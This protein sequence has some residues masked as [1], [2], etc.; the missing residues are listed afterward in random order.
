MSISFR[1]WNIALSFSFVAGVFGLI[2]PA[3]ATEF[4][5]AHV[6]ETSHPMHVAAV[7]AADKF[8]ACTQSR[9]SISVFPASTLGSE[10]AINEQ[11]R[12][13]SID[14]IFNGQIFA[15][16]AYKPLAIGAAPFIFKDRAQALRYRTSPVFKELWQGWNKSTG[17]TIQ[18]AGYFGAFNVTSNVPVEKPSDM[19]NMKIRVPD[20]PIWL[21]FP[22]AVGANPTPVALAEVYLALQQGLV[23]ASAN[24][25]PITYAFK[26][27]EVQKFVNPTAHMMEY[28][29]W[30]TGKHVMD[31]ISAEDKKCMQDAAD[32]YAERSTQLI[33]EQE[34]SLR[35]KMEAEKLVI[36]TKPDIAAFQAAVA[37]AVNELIKDMGASPDLVSKIKGI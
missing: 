18:S 34:D 26:F 5:L 3:Y 19:N 12:F 32:Y 33:V 16:S 13:G 11:I 35:T 25:L 22:R 10:K 29:F 8:K 23:N 1:L 24:P 28:V 21:A 6:Y 14:I 31:K 36:F 30:I 15:S 17:Q 37:P 2:D 27:Y 20:A 7:E 9:H 4:K